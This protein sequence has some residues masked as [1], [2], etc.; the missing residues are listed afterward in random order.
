MPLISYRCPEGHEFTRLFQAKPSAS[1]PC[2]HEG[3]A[4]EASRKLGAP[5][6]QSTYTVSQGLA[7]DVEVSHSV[8]EAEVGK[9]EKG[10]ANDD[11]KLKKLY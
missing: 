1:V 2:K 11:H 6:S 5:A 9:I 8:I 3:C 10:Y 7:R 4:L